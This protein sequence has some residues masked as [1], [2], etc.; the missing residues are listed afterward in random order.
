MQ[1]WN[2]M[3]KVDQAKVRVNKLI[4]MQMILECARAKGVKHT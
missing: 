3:I 2:K 1:I 4:F